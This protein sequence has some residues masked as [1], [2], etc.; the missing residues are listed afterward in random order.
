MNIWLLK[1]LPP[2][3]R[4]LHL[5]PHFRIRTFPYARKSGDAEAGTTHRDQRDRLDRLIGTHRTILKNPDETI[6]LQLPLRNPPT[7]RL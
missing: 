2:Y 3:V 7:L 6:E 4:L 1:L 5:L